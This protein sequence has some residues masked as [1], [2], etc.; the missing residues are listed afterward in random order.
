M[1]KSLTLLIFNIVF[2]F[3]SCKS[4]FIKKEPYQTQSTVVN[5]KSITS[6]D[7]AQVLIFTLDED[8]E[9][10]FKKEFYSRYKS[11]REIHSEIT[12]YIARIKRYKNKKVKITYYKNKMGD[13]VVERINRF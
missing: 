4:P 10:L 13:L 12:E 9:I 6:N 8:K 2:I 1:K 3:I 7:L 5:I 11:R